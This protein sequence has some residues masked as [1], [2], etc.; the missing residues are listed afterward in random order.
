MPTQLRAPLVADA[1]VIPAR[2]REMRQA[3]EGFRLISATVTVTLLDDVLRARYEYEC[4]LETTGDAS[5]RWWYYHLPVGPE[6]VSEVRAWD[7]RGRL[8]PWI[9][10]EDG[11]G[12]RLEVRLRD[13]VKPGERYS[14]WFSYESTIRPVVAGVGRGRTVT[15]M[16][17]VI[18][19]IPCALLQVHVELPHGAEPISVRPACAEDEGGRV[20][21]RVRA[22]RTL[23]TVSFLVAYRRTARR[24]VHVPILSAASGYLG[25]GLG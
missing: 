4:H 16:D 14:F 17:W 18:F 1:I 13:P 6:Q 21:Y 7:A 22:L 10:A 23:E 11:P 5:A 19:N 25:S 2:Y 12:A 20:S 8:Q 24:P 9:G 3:M 15:F